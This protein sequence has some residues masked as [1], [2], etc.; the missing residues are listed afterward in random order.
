[1]AIK[2]QLFHNS[3]GFCIEVGL[4][5]ANLRLRFEYFDGNFRR[6]WKTCGKCTRDEARHRGNLLRAADVILTRTTGRGCRT[7]LL[8]FQA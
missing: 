8:A 2:R 4:S 5:A 3:C 7:R 1:M 6:C